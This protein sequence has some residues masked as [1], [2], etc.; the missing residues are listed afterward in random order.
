MSDNKRKRKQELTRLRVKWHKKKKSCNIFEN[1][2]ESDDSSS[3]SI[4]NVQKCFMN[5]EQFDSYD[6]NAMEN[7]RENVNITHHSMDNIDD[8][9]NFRDSDQVDFE[10]DELNNTDEEM[11]LLETNISENE[12]DNDAEFD[13][14]AELR[15]WAL[16]KN[17]TIL[18]TRLDALLRILKV[19][20]LSNLPKS[21]KLF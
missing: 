20:L 9:N 10:I 7:S 13:E 1:E 14:I 21:S 18:H 3:A 15:A 8:E 5:I 6:E 2:G 12:C 16:S 11:D 4:L 19:R 17:P